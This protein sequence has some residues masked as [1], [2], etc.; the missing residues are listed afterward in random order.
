MDW[1]V[2][3]LLRMIVGCEWDGDN[4]RVGVGGVGDEGCE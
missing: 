1:L 3:R 2:F 4:G